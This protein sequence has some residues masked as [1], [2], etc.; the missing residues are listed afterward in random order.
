MTGSSSMAS[1]VGIAAIAPTTL[2]L[3][4]GN[5][6]ADHDA[7]TLAGLEAEGLDCLAKCPPP[8]GEETGNE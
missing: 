4:A 7:R 5:S 2:E 1:R 8:R 3:L 6:V